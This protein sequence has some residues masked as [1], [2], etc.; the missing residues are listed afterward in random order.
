[1]RFEGRGIG[2]LVCLILGVHSVCSR[3]INGGFGDAIFWTS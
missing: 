3:R 1:V 2:G